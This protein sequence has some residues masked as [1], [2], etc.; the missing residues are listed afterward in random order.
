MISIHL[1]LQPSEF[2]YKKIQEKKEHYLQI[3]LLS[4]LLLLAKKEK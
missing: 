2:K 1:T 4:K 3:P